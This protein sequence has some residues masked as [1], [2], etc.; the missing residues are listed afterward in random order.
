MIRINRQTDYAIRVVLA[1]AKHTERQRISTTEVQREMLIP[2]AFLP[3]I[4]AE[5]GRG[6]FILTFPGRDGGLELARPAEQ[7]NLRQVVEY[8][9]GPISV[10]DCI[11]GRTQ[12]PFDTKCPVRCRW[13]KLQATIIRELEGFTFD[14]LAQDALL[15][16]SAVSLPIFD[17]SE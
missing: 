10:S 2:A 1:L 3:R 13:G 9:E 15:E 5:L 8:F 6:G 7:I 12:C 14:E 11:S 16:E 17:L 4:V